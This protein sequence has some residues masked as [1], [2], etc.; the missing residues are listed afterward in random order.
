[1]GEL[2]QVP[3][4]RR[5]PLGELTPDSQLVR[6]VNEP[7]PEILPRRCSFSDEP[8]LKNRGNTTVSSKMQV[9]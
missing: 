6:E 8:L 3:Q 2:T 9:L 7:L 4:T 5:T 1:M